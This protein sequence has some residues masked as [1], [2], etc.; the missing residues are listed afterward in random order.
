MAVSLNLGRHNVNAKQTAQSCQQN[1]QTLKHAS[2][3]NDAK[4]RRKMRRRRGRLVSR[5]AIAIW[6]RPFLGSG[7][8][9]GTR[10]RTCYVGREVRGDPTRSAPTRRAL[11]PVY[12]SAICARGVT[13]HA[14]IGVVALGGRIFIAGGELH[15]SGATQNP[16][17]RWEIVH[18]C[19]ARHLLTRSSRD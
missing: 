5:A 6:S 14:T 17:V 2:C 4:Q 13:F 18:H 12:H 3:D 7:A 1:T 9:K 19:F 11:C 16:R 15:N 10:L 8:P